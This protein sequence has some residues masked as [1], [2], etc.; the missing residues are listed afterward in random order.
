MLSA[1]LE[2]PQ[3][4]PARLKVFLPGVREHESSGVSL[5]QK[6]AKVFFQTCQR[7]A[8]GR[9]RNPQLPGGGRQSSSLP[10]RHIHTYVIEIRFIHS[11][12][13]RAPVLVER[14]IRVAPTQGGIASNAVSRRQRTH[15][16]AV[17][18]QQIRQTMKEM[19]T[20]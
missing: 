11:N 6:E 8:D 10:D 12:T 3:R 17:A 18:V 2:K 1:I 19:V 14:I 15:A 4:A 16:L 13:L 5:Y 20:L 9:G 7:P